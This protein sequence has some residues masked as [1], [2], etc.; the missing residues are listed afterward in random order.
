M[1]K[2]SDYRIFVIEHYSDIMKTKLFFLTL[3]T[4]I[5]CGCGSTINTTRPDSFSVG[6][7]TYI[8]NY[9]VFQTVDTH[10]ALVADNRPS[11]LIIAIR[12][13]DYFNS[14]YD[15]KRIDGWFVMVDTYTYETVPDKYGRTQIKTIPL[16]VPKED[17]IHHR[18]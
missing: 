16:V 15:K 10:F 7:Y 18:Y 12:T 5:I 8:S 4:V 11:R 13:S 3:I 2:T 17:Y 14:F 1:I 9:Y 6:K